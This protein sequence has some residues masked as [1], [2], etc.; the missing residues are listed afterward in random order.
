M[1]IAMVTGVMASGFT[2]SRIKR[3]DAFKRSCEIHIERNQGDLT[4]QARQQLDFERRQLG[5]TA[6]DA[7]HLLNQ[8]LEAHYGHDPEK[9][10]TLRP[11]E[12][13]KDFG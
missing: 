2:Y 7:Q 5:F 10:S 1:L 12:Q 9:L 4:N 3:S 6:Q 8:V 13:A 11:S